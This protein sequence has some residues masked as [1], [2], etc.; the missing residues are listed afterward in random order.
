[1]RT[2]DHWQRQAAVA[3]ARQPENSSRAGVDGLLEFVGKVA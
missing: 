1:M 3:N 2:R